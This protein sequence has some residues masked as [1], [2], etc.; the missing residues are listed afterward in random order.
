MENDPHKNIQNLNFVNNIQ[1][2]NLYDDYT[3]YRVFAFFGAIAAT[4]FLSWLI[5]KLLKNTCRDLWRLEMKID[6]DVIKRRLIKSYL[7]NQEKSS[8]GSPKPSNFSTFVKD[9]N[10]K[11]RL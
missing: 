8:G 1:D 4:L 5:P 9:A 6:H 7:F 2:N 10:E 3:L 11:F